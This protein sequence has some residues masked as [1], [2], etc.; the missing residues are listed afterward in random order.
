MRFDSSILNGVAS[1]A[2][3]LSLFRFLHAGQRVVELAVAPTVPDP[4][5][6][7]YLEVPGIEARSWL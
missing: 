4:L 3:A 7:A 5:A 6:P 2:L 1:P